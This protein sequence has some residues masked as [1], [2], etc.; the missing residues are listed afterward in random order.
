MNRPN[1]PSSQLVRAVPGATLASPK[2]PKKLR[3]RRKERGAAV[4]VV[5]MVLTLLTGLG[6][7]ATRSAS[8]VDVAAGNARQA[9]QAQYVADLGVE[10]TTALLATGLGDTYVTEG[11]KGTNT[12]SQNSGLTGAFCYA[13]FYP[14]IEGSLSNV[15]A[16]IT[17]L[18]AASATNAGQSS[19]G[20]YLQGTSDVTGEFVVEMTDLGPAP[21]CRGCEQ[22]DVNSS[23]QQATVV[24]TSI[25]TVHPN[26]AAASA[27]QCNALA[28]SV[29]DRQMMRASAVVAPLIR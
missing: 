9:L 14:E 24:F 21:P 25:A 12:C 10:T 1:A 2:L 17:L 7:W 28:S 22:D 16:G 5:A 13:F 4:F 8:L 19:L 18:S 23:V 15:T 11:Q 3:S 20:P 6:I 26:I 27:T 29:A